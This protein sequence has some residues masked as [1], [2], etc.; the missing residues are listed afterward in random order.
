MY[1]FYLC[2]LF[3]ANVSSYSHYVFSALVQEDSEVITFEVVLSEYKGSFQTFLASG[4]C[5][6][7]FRSCE[8]LPGDN[9]MMMMV[10]TMMMNGSQEE[11]LEWTFHLYDLD[12]DG[13]ITREEMEDVAL[14]VSTN[15]LSLTQYK[16]FKSNTVQI[17]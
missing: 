2:H 12:G 9:E 8:W 17:C 4:F 3:S 11:K 10:M 13:V 1:L 14:S 5:R 6:R 15:M 16:Y 7:S